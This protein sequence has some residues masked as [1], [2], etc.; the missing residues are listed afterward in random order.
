MNYRE[1]ECVLLEECFNLS[2]LPI[3]A[4]LRPFI[5]NLGPNLQSM[6]SN[7]FKRFPKF[8]EKF[9][10]AHDFVPSRLFLFQFD[11]GPGTT[12]HTGLRVPQHIARPVDGID[13]FL[14]PRMG[15]KVLFFSNYNNIP[16]MSF[17][18]FSM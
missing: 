5:E 6:G 8:R 17:K 10:M 18:F 16:T 13:G 2:V 11:P 14:N 4:S 7:D 1:F 12:S 9:P 15:S 3:R